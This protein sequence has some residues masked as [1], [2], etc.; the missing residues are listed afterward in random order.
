[1][2]K[3]WS[4]KRERQYDHIKDGLKSRGKSEEVAEEIAARTVNK[5]RAQHGEAKHAAP[6]R[7]ATCPAPKRRAALASRRGWPHPRPALRGSEAQGHLRPV[8]HDQGRTGARRRPLGH[9]PDGLVEGGHS[10]VELVAAGP[11]GH[12]ADPILRAEGGSPRRF[13]SAIQKPVPQLDARP[14]EAAREDQRARPPTPPELPEDLDARV[15]LLG[16]WQW[17]EGQF[18]LAS[19]C[20]WRPPAPTYA[21]FPAETAAH[22]VRLAEDAWNARDPDRVVQVHTEDTSLAQSR[23]VPR[24]GEQVPRSANGPANSIRLV[25]ELAC[26]LPNWVRLPTNGTTIPT[27]GSSYGKQ[28]FDDAGYSGATPAS[29]TCGSASR[30]A[31]STGRQDASEAPGAFRT[32]V[33]WAAARP[34]ACAR[35]CAS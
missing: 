5:E 22:K 26:R 17:L 16:E 12:A 9:P 25:K 7:C 34:P 33:E 32:G 8:H 24:G 11:H 19:G 4:A 10:L 30:T 18:V 31:C 29:M 28:E 15:R 3:A 2:P 13:S 6:S 14:A 27:S 21:P 1:M 20:R 23:R 35:H